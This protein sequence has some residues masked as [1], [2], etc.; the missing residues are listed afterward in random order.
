MSTPA[1]DGTVRRRADLRVG[2]LLAE[3]GEGRVYELPRE[4]ALVYKA[5]RQPVPHG[6]LAELVAWPT[7][8]TD[9]ALA[10]RVTASTAWPAA[11]VVDGTAG[12]AGAAG[13]V[14]AAGVL[15]PRAPRRFAVRHRDGT[16]RLATLSY[17]TADPAHRSAAYGLQLPAPVSPERVGLVY[18][19]ARL[20]E[21]FEAVDPPVGHGDLSTKNVLWSMQRG[22]EVFVLDCDNCERFDRTG[23]PLTHSERRR[24]MTPNWDDP[25][26]PPGHNPTSTSDRYS[27]ALIFLR[28]VGA[29]NFPIQARQR[30]GE[31]V[32]VD[33]AVPPGRFGEALLSPGA[34]VW[35]LCQ[36]GLSA[37]APGQRPC[38]AAWVA[39]LEALL[40][41]LGAA[42]VMRAVWS[43]QGGNGTPSPAIAP[44]ETA[45]AADVII[46]PVPAEPR[47]AP[48]WTLVPEPAPA[49]PVWRRPQGAM[50]TRTP[51]GSTGAPVATGAGR[52]AFV[53]PASGTGAAGVSGA[54]A[55]GLAQA[56]PISVSR[57]AGV[58]L[59]QA[60]AWWL[61]LHRRTG[62][63][64]WTSGRRGSGARRVLACVAVD[65]LVLF[66]GL[67]LVAMIVAPILGL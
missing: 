11:V 23:R 60:V 40:D 55:A 35:D 6:P 28:V 5:Y 61:A 21:A 65:L 20:L 56:P 45:P 19:L 25:A 52:L 24:A 57:Q 2:E 27:L 66:I 17:L 37:A 32:T 50:V 16:T 33:F 48:Q 22:P 18:A 3:G 4:P 49:G 29:A 58:Y 41:A 54:A 39:V 51:G 42:G 38:P 30:Q 43:A 47:A 1:V 14:Q 10:A 63:D 26:V 59:A 53:G 62:R 9:P 34:P 64:L 15:L 8:L 7:H 12:G 36:R 31:A 46:R 44:P 13:G 67:F